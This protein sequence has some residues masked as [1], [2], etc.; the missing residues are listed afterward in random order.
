MHPHAH[1]AILAE[2][3]HF[4]FLNRKVP[5]IRSKSPHST[6]DLARC[7][8]RAPKNVEI[9]FSRSSPHLFAA[10]LGSSCLLATSLTYPGTSFAWL[11]L[12]PCPLGVSPTTLLLRLGFGTRDGRGSGM[13]YFRALACVPPTPRLR[14]EDAR[15]ADSVAS[16]PL[17]AQDSRASPATAAHAASESVESP[18]GERGRRC[19]SRRS[20][21]GASARRGPR[22]AF[23]CGTQYLLGGFLSKKWVGRLRES[24]ISS[25]NV[26][27]GG[28]SC[29]PP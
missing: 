16:Q 18:A 27:Q 9:D 28:I 19:A 12:S 23:F 15:S 22:A 29:H 2:I 10:T 4:F 5:A 8:V 25:I 14:V 24:K 1:V 6:C 3:L 20:R 13:R 17:W 7:E 21:Q 11:A 26:R